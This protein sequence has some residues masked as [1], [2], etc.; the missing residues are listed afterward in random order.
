[1]W[2]EIIKGR[3][4]EAQDL[5]TLQC[6]LESLDRAEQARIALLEHGLTYTDAKGMVRA[7]PEASIERDSRA[8]F[9]RALNCLHL[10]SPTKPEPPAPWQRERW[11]LDHEK[12]AS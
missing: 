2:G 3:N 10:A 5:K 7:R 12:D 8:A 11:R 6:A 4:F 9:L 1:L